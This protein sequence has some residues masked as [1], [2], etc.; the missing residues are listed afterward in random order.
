MCTYSKEKDLAMVFFFLN[1]FR[2]FALNVSSL[3]DTHEGLSHTFVQS[4]FWLLNQLGCKLVQF[5]I[6]CNVF[7]V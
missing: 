7:C 6:S 2:V 1:V 3:T 5:S 4:K